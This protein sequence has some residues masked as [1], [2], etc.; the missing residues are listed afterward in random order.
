MGVCV[1]SGHGGMCV[2]SV[3]D[4]GGRHVPSVG[5]HG[6]V[7]LCVPSVGGHRGVCVPSVEYHGGSLS[8]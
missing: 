6:C 7:C 2:T 8:H 1:L 5:G 3:V 4:N